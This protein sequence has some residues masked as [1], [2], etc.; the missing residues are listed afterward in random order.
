MSRFHIS[1][2]I[3][4]VSA[5]VLL[6]FTARPASAIGYWNMPGNFCQCFG[7]GWG[8]GYH[9]SMVL[10]PPTCE[11]IFAHDVVRLPA[12]PS[13]AGGRSSSQLP[14]YHRQPMFY[15]P[16][17]LPPVPPATTTP[18]PAAYRGPVLR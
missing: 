11:G 2:F 18:V 10:G 15:Q 4:A 6:S 3:V 7:Y 12:A 1:H 8:P 13:A 17:T 5:V 16:S 9:A 14:A